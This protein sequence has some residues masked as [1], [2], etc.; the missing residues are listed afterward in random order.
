[1]SFIVCR[2]VQRSASAAPRVWVCWVIFLRHALALF[3]ISIFCLQKSL[4]Y[5]TQVGDAVGKLETRRLLPLWEI[6]LRLNVY[7]VLGSCV[8]L[9]PP[10][11][12]GSPALKNRINLPELTTP[13][14][15]NFP[16]WGH[17]S[18]GRPELDRINGR[19]H[20]SVTL[21]LSVFVLN[22]D[23]GIWFSWRVEMSSIEQWM[24][25]ALVIKSK[26]CSAGELAEDLK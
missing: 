26:W 20:S 12:V 16:C 19:E 1:M 3:S 2:L 25:P 18:C 6:L 4:F 21:N 9:L 13:N 22:C 24:D 10:I 17:S 15:N 8:W 14:S 7:S 23:V 5:V 11:Y